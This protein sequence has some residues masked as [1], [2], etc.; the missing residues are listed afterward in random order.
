MK[1]K[2]IDDTIIFIIHVIV[3]QIADFGMS[4]DLMYES[5]YVSHGGL[6]PIKWTAPEVR[7]V[8]WGIF[9]W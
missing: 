7:I 3:I 6:I 1:T 8:G 9:E 4:R 2:T 5:Y